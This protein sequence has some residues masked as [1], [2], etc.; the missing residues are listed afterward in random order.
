MSKP[1]LRA[2]AVEALFLHCFMAIHAIGRTSRVLGSARL[3]LPKHRILGLAAVT[4]GITVGEVV[5]RL[6]ITNQSVNGPLRLLISEGYVI[7]KIGLED[8]R[9]KRLFAT[10]KGRRHYARALAPNLAKIEDAFRAAG[11]EAVRGF[12][13]VHQHL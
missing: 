1:A 10:P 8:R 4:P 13:K 12:L 7:A 6:R 11:P 2:Q 3:T 5:S 9:H